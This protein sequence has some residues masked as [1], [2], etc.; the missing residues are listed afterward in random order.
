M[1]AI[2]KFQ[3]TKVGS[4]KTK[5]MT[6]DENGYYP[7]VLGA[8]N[9]YNSSGAYY[10]AAPVVKLLQESSSF[11][12]LVNS[13]M[14][15]GECGHPD[16]NEY[17]TKEEKF[18]RVMTI[19]EKNIALHIKEVWLENT[20]GSNIKMMGMLTPSG[21]KGES[22]Q[23]SIDNPD[24]NV[25]FSI[26]SLTL[27]RYNNGKLNKYIRKIITWDH[28]YAPG[29]ETANMWD[30]PG[31]EELSTD[32]ISAEAIN[33]LI[34]DTDRLMGMESHKDDLRDLIDNLEE[35]KSRS[36]YFNWK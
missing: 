11:I 2:I 23:K 17:K 25:S 34:Q 28:V 1:S 19:D 22:L 20:Q 32:I 16:L 29:I 6:P 26:R 7:M 13:G 8:V 9:A 21:P 10:P 31:L 35:P 36:I 24:E 4:N 3:Q 12:H 5:T 33:Y 30:S 18:K 15:R 27:D 14:L